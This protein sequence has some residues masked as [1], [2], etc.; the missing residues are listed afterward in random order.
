MTPRDQTGP[1]SPPGIGGGIRSLW[2]FHTKIRIANK[3][4][5]WMGPCPERAPSCSRAAT[6][7]GRTAR[8]TTRRRSWAATEPPSDGICCGPQREPSR[9]FIAKARLGR[10]RASP[11]AHARRRLVASRP[12][13]DRQARWDSIV[14]GHSTRNPDSLCLEVVESV[15]GNAEKAPRSIFCP[16]RIQWLPDAHRAGGGGQCQS[17]AFAG[18][19]AG[20]AH[21]PNA[22]IEAAGRC[23][24][25]TLS[26]R[27]VL[28]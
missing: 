13:E 25:V 3:H 1:R 2:P 23:P 20:S 28:G 14:G 24:T 11:G 12:W 26:R 21:R 6:S 16:Q 7:S 18:L 17:L 8:K 9:R 4:K 19:R 10:L 27:S 15:Q 22:V 5:F